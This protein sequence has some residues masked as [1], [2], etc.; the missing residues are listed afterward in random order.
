M[1][2]IRIF[3]N[4][5][6]KITILV[7]VY[8]T[9]KYLRECLDSLV[10]Q[11]YK[12]IQIICIDDDSTD[13]SFD[14]LQE[15][16]KKD[17]RI[18][19]LKNEINSGQ[20]KTRNRGLKYANGDFIT[21]VDSDDYIAPDTF[22]NIINVFNNNPLTDCVLFDFIRFWD[23]GKTEP[24]VNNTDKT[25]F[26]G[27]EAMRLS[28]DWSL[29]GAYVIRADIHKKY[30]YD[31]STRYTADDI[32][33]KQHFFSSREV[34]LSS[35]K[36]FY[37]QRSES[38]SN[39]ITIRRFDVFIADYSLKKH[40][41]E[42]GVTRDILSIHE[43]LRWYSLINHWIFF[44]KNKSCFTQ[45]EQNE[46]AT[47]FDYH[48]STI[49]KSLIPLSLKLHTLY[50]PFLGTKGMKFWAIL[51]SNLRKIIPDILLKKRLKF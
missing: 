34:R 28:L 19:V 47:S 24:Y 16:S 31:E 9:E 1:F 38:I 44:A 17:N 7:A 35:G 5:D 23:D 6:G 14:I 43:R 39:A 4:M 50:I 42:L 25:V 26:T 21:F 2:D 48:V 8:N 12:N 27:E 20:S 13:G 22:E 49:D 18:L 33:T 10:N 36:Y 37:R 30:P 15:Y 45:K 29:H 32:T 11:T 40:L 51:Y 41:E 46:I 3:L